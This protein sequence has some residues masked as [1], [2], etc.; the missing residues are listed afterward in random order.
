M[1][2]WARLARSA[3]LEQGPD[4][5]LELGGRR[6]ADE[7]LDDLPFPIDDERG[8]N[9]DDASVGVRGL[10]VRDQDRI[11]E[12][13]LV[14]RSEGPDIMRAA[15]IDGESDDGEALVAVLALHRDE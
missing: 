1:A 8:R 14:V 10:L 11:V 12:G 9:S 5:L 13:D 6:V 15:R 2:A 3:C 7:P 4:R